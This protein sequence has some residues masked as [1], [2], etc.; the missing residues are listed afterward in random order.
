MVTSATKAVWQTIQDP[1]ENYSD[2]DFILRRI[3]NPTIEQT[4]YG[5][6]PLIVRRSVF[7]G[8]VR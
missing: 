3:A 7:P 5:N 1:C 4:P 8:K 6:G 2:M